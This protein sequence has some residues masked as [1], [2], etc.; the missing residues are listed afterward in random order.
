MTYHDLIESLAIVQFLCKERLLAA[1]QQQDLERVVLL[2]QYVAY[3]GQDAPCDAEVVALTLQ[4]QQVLVVL[5][6]VQ[7][8]DQ[9]LLLD[10]VLV[11]VEFL[12]AL[13]AGQNLRDLAAA[14]V[15]QV[16][17]LQV[18]APKVLVDLD[19]AGYVLQVV[20]AHLDPD[21]LEGF[22]LRVLDEVVV[23]RHEVQL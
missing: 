9:A 10:V 1:R 19:G 17:L 15:F 18:E 6:G 20:K 2:R 22:E 23:D 11:Q 16:V 8:L 3:H 5:Q 21:Q 4:T 7:D 12:D 14:A 13:V